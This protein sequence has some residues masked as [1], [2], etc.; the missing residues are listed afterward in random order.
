M[1][2]IMSTLLH[3]ENNYHSTQLHT[4]TQTHPNVYM[5]SIWQ[6]LP[7]GSKVNLVCRHVG[8]F[9]HV[10]MNNGLSRVIHV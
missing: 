3:I 9:Y 4:I 1:I 5:I 6:D 8:M 7:D 2:E 10:N